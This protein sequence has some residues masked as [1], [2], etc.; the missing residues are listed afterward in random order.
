[1]DVRF[2]QVNTRFAELRGEMDTR[3]AELRGEMDTRFAE[4]RG[5]MDARFNKQTTVTIVSALVVA[6]TVIATAVDFRGLFG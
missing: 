4:L 1:M 2:E 5:E 6:G 3:F